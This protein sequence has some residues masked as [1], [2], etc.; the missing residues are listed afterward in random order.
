[1]FAAGEAATDKKGD[2]LSIR[3]TWLSEFNESCSLAT[4]K[5]EKLIFKMNES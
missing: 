4:P 5:E 1:M 3:R 2:A